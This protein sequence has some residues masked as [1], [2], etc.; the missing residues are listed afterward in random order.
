MHFSCPARRPCARGRKKRPN[1]IITRGGDREA[2]LG[3]FAAH[4]KLLVRNAA[5]ITH[6]SLSL[7]PHTYTK[8]RANFDA[9]RVPLE[10]HRP[11]T[12]VY[13]IAK[14]TLFHPRALPLLFT[15]SVGQRRVHIYVQNFLR[16]ASYLRA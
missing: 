3:L 15:I 11:R 10:F 13:N 9:F 12:V 16:A 2:L 14:K 8:S 7:P 5:L 6:F 4:N 1:W